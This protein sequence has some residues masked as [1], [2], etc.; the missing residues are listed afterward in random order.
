MPKVCGQ[1]KVPGTDF[2]SI[3][4]G[5]LPFLG[6]MAQGAS[7]RH[8]ADVT[9]RGGL[10]YRT[11]RTLQQ[12]PATVTASE[13]RAT[14][15]ASHCTEH[16]PT[17]LGTVPS[18]YSMRLGISQCEDVVGGEEIVACWGADMSTTTR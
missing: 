15:G 7:Q 13:Q 5:L 17:E 11:E 12:S 8:D 18:P 14:R 1:T 10:Q 9:T 6:A 4:D 2:A 3:P 16:P